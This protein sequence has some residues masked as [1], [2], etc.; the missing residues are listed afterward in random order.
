MPESKVPL[1]IA[2]LTQGQVSYG[3]GQVRTIF[4]RVFEEHRTLSFQFDEEGAL[5]PRAREIAAQVAGM[6]PLSVSGVRQIVAAL[7]RGDRE[8]AER[9]AAERREQAFGSADFQEG[10]A[11]FRERRAPKFR[12]S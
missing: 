10:L 6:A 7:G 9:L 3:P 2:G 12:G 11:A 4:D 1:Q 5:W 8:A